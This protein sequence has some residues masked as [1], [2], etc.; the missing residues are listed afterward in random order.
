MPITDL[1]ATSVSVTQPRQIL[2][3]EDES[4]I[5]LNLQETLE[6]LEYSVPAVAVSAEQALHYAATL[7][8]DLVLMDIRIKGDV[9]GIQAAAQIW[10]RFQIPVIYVTGHS[11]SSTVERVR[12]TAP[13][14][15]LLK[16]I[17][18]REL[19]VAIET[20]L[21]R[22][23]RERWMTT[24]LRGIGDGVIVVD[25][26]GHIKFLN[27]VAEALT[28]WSFQEAKEQPV[29]HVFNVVHEQTRLPIANPITTATEQGI[30]IHLEGSLLLLAKDGTAL[31]IADSIAPLLDHHGRSAGFVL[32]FRDMTTRRQAEERN[33]VLERSKHLQEQ[34]LELERLNRLKDDFL[35]TISHELRTPI[36]NIKMATRMLE[37]VLDQQGLL[38]PEN[39]PGSQAVNRYMDILRSQCDQELFLVNDLLDLQR[40]NAEAYDLELTAI[41]LSV[42]LPHVGESF[43]A[44][45]EERQ[46]QLQIDVATDLPPLISDLPSLNR[47]LLELLNNACKYTPSGGQITVNVQPKAPPNTA[48]SDTAPS[49]SAAAAT[50]LSPTLLIAVCNS[51]I[52]IPAEE[53]PRIFEPFYRIPKSDRWSQGGTGLG[54]AL[55]RKLVTCLNG[56]IQAESSLG[57]TCFTVELPFQQSTRPACLTEVDT[58]Q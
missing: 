13:F 17:E 40:L 55:V 41:P 48:A 23:E 14:G 46:L 12:L 52:E 16:P 24:V 38:S 20:A 39:N 22:W 43:Q 47:I 5:A 49:R 7:H 1:E 32:V 50:V 37:L 30:V 42:W 9:D 56:S 53:L 26:A 44:Y 2:I 35:N 25:A 54:L 27:A 6:S 57:W 45:A 11:D 3:V 34:M 36:A 28:G 10:E 51:G 29:M 4:V 15:Y 33:L 58:S 19:Y 21:L 18:E 31:P 8:P